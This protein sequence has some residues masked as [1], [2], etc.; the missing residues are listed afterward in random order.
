[1]ILKQKLLHEIAT[2]TKTFKHTD[3]HKKKNRWK[4][5]YI[6]MIA[7]TFFVLNFYDEKYNN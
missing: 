5:K 6:V 4:K 3:T 1:M 2:Q 7:E